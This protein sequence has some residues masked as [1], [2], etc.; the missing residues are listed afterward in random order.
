M[1]YRL[2]Q[3][4]SLY[5]NLTLYLILVV[6]SIFKYFHSI[7]HSVFGCKSVVFLNIRWIL[8]KLLLLL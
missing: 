6:N 8:N 5:F 1:N 4:Q 3:E 7:S 2:S